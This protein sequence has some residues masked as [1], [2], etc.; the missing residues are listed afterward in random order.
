VDVIL[1]SLTPD[2][3]NF[4][5]EVARI[6]S[7]TSRAYGFTNRFPGGGGTWDEIGARGEVFVRRVF[8]VPLDL[9]EMTEVSTRHFPDVP[10]V[11]DVRST[12][13]ENGGL[14]IHREDP[15]DRVAVLVTGERVLQIRGWL[16]NRDGMRPEFY[17]VDLGEPFFWLVPNRELRPI[18][19]HPLIAER[20]LF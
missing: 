1:G 5:Y 19:T 9:D 8:R 15:P 6:R 7:A 3:E 4:A 18:H 13:R 12:K 20:G 16:V 10:G 11:G 17:R 14:P 2:E